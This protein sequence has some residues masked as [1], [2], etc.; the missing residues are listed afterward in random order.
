MVS[1]VPHIVVPTLVALAF[2]RSLPRNWV[3]A[4]A[5]VTWLPDLDYFSPGEHRVWTHNVWIPLAFLLACL[6]LWRRRDPTARFLSFAARPGWPVALLLCA[7]YWS[8]HILL[9]VFA[10]GVLLFWPLLDTNFF[11]F[12]EVTINLQ[13]GEATPVA[14][15]GTSQGA[16]EV[17]D[18]YTWLAYDHTATL[19]FLA[20][21]GLGAAGWALLRRRRLRGPSA[22]R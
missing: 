13:T 7:Y 5:P 8:S 16:P 2:F 20:A 19:A 17:S 3:M 9:D 21:V 15:A 14:D 6:L 22:K 12:Y 4:L 11:L 10:G 1:W 18:N